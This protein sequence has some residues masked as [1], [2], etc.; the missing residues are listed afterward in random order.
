MAAT[1]VQAFSGDVEISS[2]VTAANSKFSLDT[3]GTL[4]QDGEGSHGRYIKLMKYFGNA[5][6][7]KIATGSYTGSS[8]QWLSI[9]AKMTRLNQDVKIIQ[10]N[11]FGSADASRVRD[12]IVIGGGGSSFQA[13]EIK[14]YNKTSNSTYEIY[15]QIDSATSVEVEI[16]HRASTIDDDYST[17][18]TTNNGA[19]D[20]TGL[21]KIYD[22]GTTTDLRLKEGNVGIGTTNPTGQLE[23]HGEG[24]T[25]ETS[26]SQTGNM[27]GVLAL[28]SDDGTVGSGGA[29]M[30]G[31]NAGFHAAIKASLED[32]ATYTRGR[33]A[34]F[35]RSNTGDATMSHAMT[36]ADGGNVGIGTTSPGAPLEVHGADLTGQPVGTTGIISRHVSG[37]DGVLN[38]FGV[39][40]S[41]NEE[42]L[43]LQTQI[44]GRAWQSDIDGGWSYGNDSRYD[45]CLQP[46]KGNVGIGTTNPNYKLNVVGDV[47]ISG[48]TSNYNNSFRGGYNNRMNINMNLDPDTSDCDRM[49]ISLHDDECVRIRRNYNSAINSALFFGKVGIGTTNPSLALHVH[50]SSTIHNAAPDNST[51]SGLI[52][53]RNTKTGSTP[54]SMAIGVDQSHGFGYLNAAGNAQ[55][56]PICIN[57]RGGNVGIGKTNPATKL[58]VET[59]TGESTN[60]VKIGSSLNSGSSQ[61]VSGIEFAAN[62]AFFTN[63]NAQRSAA[64]I[65]SGFYDGGAADWG[66]AYIS[67]KTPTNPSSGVINDVLTI[68]GGA[69]GIGT[70]N[71]AQ[72]LDVR[73]VLQVG[74]GR[75]LIYSE[76]LSIGT[77][78]TNVPLSGS[79]GAFIVMARGADNDD[80][81][82]VAAA[83]DDSG[84]AAG[85]IFYMVRSADYA[86]SNILQLRMEGNDGNLQIS[87]S[88]GNTRTTSVTVFRDA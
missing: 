38:I 7:W 23:V 49:T 47:A 3:N 25:S 36:I 17:V 51:D 12:P 2:N 77:G 69:V 67:L 88:G 63:D 71:P 54:Y 78:W 79:R 29:V 72:K 14:V 64:Q 75:T 34:F 18:A 46:Y 32:G 87:M 86:S 82:M 10:F 28:R 57:T 53:L 58:H 37:L 85:N 40:A 6:N 22:S 19:I 26:F 31:S 1:N 76:Y 60:F 70:T 65:T 8:F 15:L 45:L 39:Q 33:L 50:G 5:S 83:S 80:S 81:C 59:P 4:K 66:D 84:N 68:R 62:P 61:S 35:T 9:R 52:L 20:E 74:L 41:N 13:N 43:G 56:Q 21:T 48:G 42:T 11:Y 44:D 73:G 30:F 16:S 55:V 27:G 24:Q